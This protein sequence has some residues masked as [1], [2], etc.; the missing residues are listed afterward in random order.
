MEIGGIRV[1]R[2]LE[3]GSPKS[4]ACVVWSLLFVLELD[5]CT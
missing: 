3:V 4:V 2:L 5:A 1:K